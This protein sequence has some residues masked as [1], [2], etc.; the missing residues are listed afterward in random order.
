[1]TENNYN[2]SD[3]FTTFIAYFRSLQYTLITQQPKMLTFDLIS[4]IGGIL[5]LFIGVSFVSLFEITEILMQITFLLFSKKILN[6][7]YD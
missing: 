3:N 2:P 6:Y 4:S 5:G 7:N 1:M